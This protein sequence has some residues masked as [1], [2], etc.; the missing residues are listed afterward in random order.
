MFFSYF[1]RL[2]FVYHLVCKNIDDSLKIWKYKKDIVKTR[3]KMDSNTIHCIHFLSLGYF[4]LLKL[5]NRVW[6]FT[7]FTDSVVHLFLL[8]TRM[9]SL[10][11]ENASFEETNALL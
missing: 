2:L 11:Y 6:I 10:E 7:S 9:R 8:N 3:L 4:H 1:D 5:N